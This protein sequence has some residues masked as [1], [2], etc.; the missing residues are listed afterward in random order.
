VNGA[1]RRPRAAA[2]PGTTHG[3]LTWTGRLGVLVTAGVALSACG[4][5]LPSLSQSEHLPPAVRGE[6]GSAPWCADMERTASSLVALGRGESS[7]VAARIVRNDERRVESALRNLPRRSGAA[8]ALQDAA[9]DA[10]RA[11]SE[12]H[13]DPGAGLI[14]ASRAS[15]QI[16]LA[17]ARL[18][19]GGG[20]C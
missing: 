20:G 19:S 15:S 3:A 5:G 9:H 1:R 2:L 12:L 11:L 10:G 4:A 13:D 14:D 6:P 17:L 18:H 8:A 7:G 16:T